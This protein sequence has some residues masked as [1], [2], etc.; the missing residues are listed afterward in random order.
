M[1]CGGKTILERTL[2]PESCLSL[3]L[4][5]DLSLHL[6]HFGTFLCIL[7]LGTLQ[8]ILGKV[9]L[10]LPPYCHMSSVSTI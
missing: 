6:Q 5:I 4:S 9:S 10:L 7:T 8:C 3:P 1:K 2:D